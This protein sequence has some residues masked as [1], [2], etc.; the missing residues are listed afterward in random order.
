MPDTHEDRY[1]ET[2]PTEELLH[3]IDILRQSEWN[4]RR[5]EL[6]HDLWWVGGYVRRLVF[7]APGK[8]VI[9]EEQ[10]NEWK[11]AVA[12]LASLKSGQ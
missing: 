8:P 4:T 5:G 12:E 10:A 6:V 3:V 2:P 1:P 7:G 9:A 11:D